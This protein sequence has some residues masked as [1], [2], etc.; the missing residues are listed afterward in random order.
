VERGYSRSRKRGKSGT[1][2]ASD[3]QNNKRR[4]IYQASMERRTG[5]VKKENTS[6][7]KG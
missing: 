7:P 2:M 3:S 5:Q 4:N 1:A 6:C